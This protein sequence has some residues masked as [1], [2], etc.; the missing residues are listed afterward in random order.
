MHI[1]CSSTAEVKGEGSIDRMQG[2]YGFM[3]TVMDDSQDK[4][5]IKISDPAIEDPIYDNKRGE[6]DYTE[7]TSK[8]PFSRVGKTAIFTVTCWSSRRKALLFR[9]TLY[10]PFLLS[11]D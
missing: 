2:I 3:L 4:F 1:D 7:P 11:F 5:R 9:H 6:G 10:S 8:S